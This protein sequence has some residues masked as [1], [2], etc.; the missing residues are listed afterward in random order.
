MGDAKAQPLLCA[1]VLSELWGRLG[2][3]ARVLVEDQTCVCPTSG[4]ARVCLPPVMAGAGLRRL[5]VV[6]ARYVARAA[7]DVMRQ[8]LD[9]EVP[10][11]S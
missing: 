2:G 3:S 1:M 11:S 10:A 9:P 4:G 6:R 5:L 7:V 8:G